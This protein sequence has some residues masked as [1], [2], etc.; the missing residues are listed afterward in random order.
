[1]ADVGSANFKQKSKMQKTISAKISKGDAAAGFTLIEVMVSIA[2]FLLAMTVVS[3]LFI[4]SLRAHRKILAHS[5]MIGEISY[6]LEHI[7]RG[8]RMA[9]KSDVNDACLQQGENFKIQS[10]KLIFKNRKA[11]G[12]IDCIKFY[13]SH[14]TDYPSG[15]MAL[16]EE[17]ND[18]SGPLPLTSPETNVTVFS[19]VQDSNSGWDQDDDLQPRVTLYI[20]TED[21]EGGIFETQTTISQRDLDVAE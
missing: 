17:R 12:D 14:P 1:V 13:Y 11:N 15:V 10:G 7:S 8:L 18:F 19:V 20:K 5:Q 9:K 3:E 21:K 16:M 6:D 2:I 4:F